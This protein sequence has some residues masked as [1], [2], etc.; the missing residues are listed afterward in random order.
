MGAL[1]LA[2]GQECG[3]SVQ[4][5]LV[6]FAGAVKLAARVVE[7]AV[8][9]VRFLR[10]CAFPHFSESERVAVDVCEEVFE[11][12]HVFECGVVVV[13][14]FLVPVVGD[15]TRAVAAEADGDGY[16]VDVADVGGEVVA[17]FVAECVPR[18]GDR[19][20][21]GEAGG[22]GGEAC[23]GFGDLVDLG[24]VHGWAS[25][26]LVVGVFSCVG[27]SVA[28]VW[29]RVLAQSR[30][31]RRRALW[32]VSRVPGGAGA[33]WLVGCLFGRVACVFLALRAA[34]GVVWVWVCSSPLFLLLP[35]F[36]F[37]CGEAKGGGWG[38]SLVSSF[39]ASWECGFWWL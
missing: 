29:A 32:V 20:C 7:E 15:E 4:C 21:D 28:H 13:S 5:A 39:C 1:L 19:L 16:G 14:D 37:G 11:G 24:G 36:P 34:I 22:A 35:V 38:E 23:C 6:R 27:F 26:S 31:R 8:A 10:V 18:V 33:A 12:A 17:L 2:F 30:E 9:L 25:F 3:H